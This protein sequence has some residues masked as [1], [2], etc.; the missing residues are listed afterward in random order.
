MGGLTL[1]SHIAS[2]LI[3]PAKDRKKT[4][5]KN[6]QKFSKTINGLIEQNIP[7]GGLILASAS[8]LINN[9]CPARDVRPKHSFLA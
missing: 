1:A 9:I 8:N 7:W 5:K 6:P 2:D 3:C 4:K